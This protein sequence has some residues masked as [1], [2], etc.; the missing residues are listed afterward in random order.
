MK[1]QKKHEYVVQGAPWHPLDTSWGSEAAYYHRMSGEPIECTRDFVI[2]RYL[3]DGDT[4]P[5]A[6]LLVSGHAPGP[7]VLRHLSKMLQPADGTEDKIPF[8][9]DVKDRLGRKGRRRDPE[10]PWRN[11]LISKNVEREIAE[12]EKYEFDAI[13]NVASMMPNAHKAYQTVRDAYDE[14]HRKKRK[15]RKLNEK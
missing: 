12:G 6:A 2:L 10:I 9:L 5:L 3:F 14:R 15:P 13:L 7:A 4:R 8:R 11:F 1:K